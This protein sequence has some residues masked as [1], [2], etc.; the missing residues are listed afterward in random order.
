MRGES[1]SQ[2]ETGECCGDAYH[3]KTIFQFFIFF[4]ILFASFSEL[5]FIYLMAVS[6]LL[7]CYKCNNN[8]ITST[9]IL[10][11]KIGI[12]HSIFL[13]FVFFFSFSSTAVAADALNKMFTKN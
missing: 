6:F 3:A 10:P 13:S 7:A 8:E 12:I 11:W 9:T 5:L 4:E 1:Q 2:G